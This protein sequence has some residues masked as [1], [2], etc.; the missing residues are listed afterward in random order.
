MDFYR[1]LACVPVIAAYQGWRGGSS[2][3]V[4][5][6]LMSTSS[7]APKAEDT[8]HARTLQD[9]SCILSEVDSAAHVLCRGL[10]E[11]SL[12]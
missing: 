4:P 7:P 11:L 5:G 9:R 6:E 10:I 12:D 1:L 8:Q 3:F 2:S